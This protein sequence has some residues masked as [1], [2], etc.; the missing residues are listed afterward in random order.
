[1][2]VA[3]AAQTELADIRRL[4]R[5]A[6][7]RYTDCAL[8]DL[9]ALLAASAAVTGSA[10]GVLW[11]FL[12]VQPEDRPRTL[13]QAAPTRAYL[14]SL[15]LRAGY[16]PT[17]HFAQL[18]ARAADLLRCRGEAIQVV[19]YGGESWLFN[20]LLAAGFSV[21]AQVQFYE[22]NNPQRQSSHTQPTVAE[23][24]EMR[25]AA[26]QH[27]EELAELDAAAFPPLWHFGYKDMVELLMRAR[28]QIAVRGDVIAGYTASIVN[29]AQ[30]LH[31]ARLAV[32]PAF[33]GQGIGRQLM[34][35]V[36]AYA[37]AQG[38]QRVMLNTQ[39][40]NERSQR[41]YRSFGFRATSRPVPVLTAIV[42]E[43]QVV[44]RSPRQ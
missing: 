44:E 31:L 42:G 24:A 35:D 34:R 27:L 17:E 37:S 30:E 23:F 26:P 1:M 25:P 8:E 9:P 21:T 39:T 41:L 10:E 5:T 18:F 15:A 13:P 32:R 2:P 19:A 16:A 29:S 22:F 36:L 20:A 38:Y 6:R 7:R 33:Q 43:R 4:L 3:I 40:D 12:C 14:R 11:G 28:L